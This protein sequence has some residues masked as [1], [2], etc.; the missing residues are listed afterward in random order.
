MNDNNT[1]IGV[2]VN[3]PMDFNTDNSLPDVTNKTGTD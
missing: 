2:K 1:S 3:T